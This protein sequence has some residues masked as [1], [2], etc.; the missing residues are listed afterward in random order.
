M[1][2]RRSSLFEGRISLHENRDKKQAPQE[3]GEHPISI[4]R[5]FVKKTRIR[6]EMPGRG[7]VHLKTSQAHRN[8][9]R[10]I[11]SY[12]KNGYL[13]VVYSESLSEKREKKTRER[14]KQQ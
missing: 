1:I 12:G 8:I 3:N 7:L 5:Q 11:Q 4:G 6:R 14:G 9:R 10:R 2:K 13:V